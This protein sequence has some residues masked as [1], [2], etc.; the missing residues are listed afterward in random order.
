MIQ[1]PQ[2]SV[3][4]FFIPLIDVLTLLFCIFLLLPLV[5]PVDEDAETT[6]LLNE[7]RLHQLQSEVERLRNEGK[8]VAQHLNEEIEQRRK[9]KLK[10]LQDRLVVRVLEIDPNTGK[11]YY[12][13]PERTEVSNQAEA[14]ELIKRDRAERGVEQRDLYY[15]ILYPR[16]RGSS[17]PTRLQREQYDRWFEGVA[18]GYDIPGRPAGKG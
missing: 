3:T 1:L 14:H 9:E 7:E 18:L 10:A 8:E 5:K 13:G 11:L 12:R 2:R 17:Y 16:D 15:L 6:R 4:R